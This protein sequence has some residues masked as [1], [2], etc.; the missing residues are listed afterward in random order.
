VHQDYHLPVPERQRVQRKHDYSSF[1]N[2][3]RGCELWVAKHEERLRVAVAARE[4]DWRRSRGL[5]GES[6][7]LPSRA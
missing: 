1:P 6:R 4:L 5:I 7:A 3:V 2:G